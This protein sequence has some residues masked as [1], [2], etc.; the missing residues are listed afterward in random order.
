MRTFMEVLRERQF[1]AYVFAGSLSFA[2]LFVFVAG[3]PAL[4]M[5]TY[6]VNAH[7]FGL[8]FATLAGGM[9]CG[10]Q[11]NHWLLRRASGRAV[12]EGALI[13]Q[14]VVG[15][16]LL[17]VTLSGIA[18]LTSMLVLLFLYLFCAGITYPNAAALALEPFSKNI[19][20]AS[21]L[22]GFLQLG[23]GSVAAALVGLLDDSGP[24]PMAVVM[25]VCAALGWFVL[26]WQTRNLDA[27]Q[28]AVDAA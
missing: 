24:R 3:S 21:S 16:V 13:V 6:G 10:G 22:L 9:I 23:L 28:T 8:I 15:A 7:E 18:G 17:T 20:S 25:A 14:V 12:F 5:Q 1:R 27:Q 2:G 11:L 4:F 19:G 26:R